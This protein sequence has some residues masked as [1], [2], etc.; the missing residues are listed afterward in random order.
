VRNQKKLKIRAKKRVSHHQLLFIASVLKKTK[1]QI[2]TN[3]NNHQQR[4]KGKEKCLLLPFHGRRMCTGT[5][6]GRTDK[7]SYTH[8]HHVPTTRTH[9]H[10]KR[11][12]RSFGKID[13]ASTVFSCLSNSLFCYS[14]ML[15]DLSGVPSWYISTFNVPV[16]GETPS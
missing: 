8:T 6:S 11:T 9:T 13:V 1:N 7:Y 14:K 16:R 3:E 5:N 12:E 15:G 2:E 10:I 4:T